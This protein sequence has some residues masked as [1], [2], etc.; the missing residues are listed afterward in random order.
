MA[1][2][3]IPLQGLSQA[4]A[5]FD[6]AATKVSRLAT[7]GTSDTPAD[8]VDLSAAA[9]QMIEAKNAF[10]ANLNVAHSYDQLQQATLNILG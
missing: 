5:L 7:Q 2:L 6:S 4:S 10:Q 1:G 9:V 8:T 3:S